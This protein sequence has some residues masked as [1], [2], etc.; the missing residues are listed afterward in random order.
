[1]S[2]VDFYE[3]LEISPNANSETIDR[4]FRHLAQRYHPDNPATADRSR[5]DLVLEAHH[6]LKDAEK[7][8]QYDF[9]YKNYISDRSK[10]AEDAGDLGGIDYDIAIQ[11]KLLALFYAKCRRNVKEPGIG[12]AELSMLLDFPAEHLEFHLWYLKEKK[13]IIRREDG[14]LSITIDGVDRVNTREHLDLAKRLL[15]DQS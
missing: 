5:F 14:L 9:E 4:V 10:L 13:W 15:T 6:I 11:T 12:D 1:V 3:V 2:F 7:R 8:V